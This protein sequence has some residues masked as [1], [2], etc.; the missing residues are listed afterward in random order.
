MSRLHNQNSAG[1]HVP[2][3]RLFLCVCMLSYQ[4]ATPHARVCHCGTAH[5]CEQ[6][7][8]RYAQ[9]KHT[10]TGLQGPFRPDG[11]WVHSHVPLPPQALVSMEL[12]FLYSSY[13]PTYLKNTVSV[14]ISLC[15]AITQHITLWCVLSCKLYNTYQMLQMEVNYFCSQGKKHSSQ[16]EKECDNQTLFT[17][18]I[19]Q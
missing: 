7:G 12:S 3:P 15:P 6:R 16:T 13:T 11:V 5:C 9:G 18:L 17:T 10:S 8:W 4:V 14:Y 2:S 19:F 1:P